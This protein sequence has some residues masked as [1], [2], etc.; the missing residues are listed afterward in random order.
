VITPTYNS[1]PAVQI[2]FLPW[3]AEPEAQA[4]HGLD[5]GIMLLRDTPWNRGKRAYKMLPYMSC[6]VPVVVSPIGMAA[7]VCQMAPVT[8]C[9]RTT[10]DWVRELEKLLRNP[11]LAAA[12]GRRAR[13]VVLQSFSIHSLAPKLAAELL[14]VAEREPE[15]AGGKRCLAFSNDEKD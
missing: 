12:M 10:E 2:E 7:E 6:G 15:I 11:Q 14:R 9:A 5:I 8:A 4:I 13:E 3:S 1:L